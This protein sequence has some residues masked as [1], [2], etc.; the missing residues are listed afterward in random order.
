[1]SAAAGWVNPSN[2][3][4]IE[5]RHLIKYYEDKALPNE[6]F[7]YSTLKHAPILYK[8]GVYFKLIFASKFDGVSDSIILIISDENGKSISD[9]RAYDGKYI[10]VQQITDLKYLSLDDLKQYGVKPSFSFAG[11]RRR[12]TRRQRKNRRKSRR[13]QRR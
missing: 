13:H 4:N 6:R 10:R 12:S 9:F 2:P 5:T 8:E 3:I 7:M 1:M 11:G